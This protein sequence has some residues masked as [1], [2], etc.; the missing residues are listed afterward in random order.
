MD[1]ILLNDI[2]HTIQLSL[3]PSFL[4]TAISAILT[5][6]TSR[7]SRAVDRARW[8]EENYAP[9]GHPKHDAQVEQLRLI[10]RRMAYANTAL[11][12][13]T[14]SAV[15]ICVVIGGIFTAALLGWSL[16]HLMSAAFI[17]A[18]LLLIIGLG[19]FLFEVRTAVLATRIQDELLERE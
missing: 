8:I 19:L 15:L 10:E 1:P 7:L 3:A 6:L 18:M 2:A 14:I 11:V 16:G 4:L 12:L 9:K 5:L 17:V 13:C